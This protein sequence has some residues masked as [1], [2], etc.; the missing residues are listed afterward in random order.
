MGWLLR[1]AANRRELYDRGGRI[2]SLAVRTN[3]AFRNKPAASVSKL[4]Q[5]AHFIINL[6]QITANCTPYNKFTANRTFYNKFIAKYT[7][8]INCISYI[9]YINCINRINR[10]N[11]INSINSINY[12]NYNYIINKFLYYHRLL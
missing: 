6:Q 9:N 4:R 11:C 1:F 2:W 12:I 8:C 7:N 10:T 3:R 5:T